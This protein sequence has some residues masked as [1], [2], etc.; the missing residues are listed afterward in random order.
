MLRNRK[1]DVLQLS[2]VDFTVKSTL[3]PSYSLPIRPKEILND[4]HFFGER[5]RLLSLFLY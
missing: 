5:F 3:H 2:A 1:N 4:P